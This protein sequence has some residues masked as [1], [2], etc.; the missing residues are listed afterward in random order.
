MHNISFAYF[1]KDQLNAKN[2]VSKKRRGLHLRPSR[3]RVL[4]SLLCNDYSKYFPLKVN[5]KEIVK[6]TEYKYLTKIIVPSEIPY[7]NKMLKLSEIRIFSSS[8]RE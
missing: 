1:K 8:F 6:I 5:K 2:D 4:F 7:R 3:R